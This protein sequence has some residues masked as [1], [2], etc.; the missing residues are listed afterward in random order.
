MMTR[1]RTS[2][3]RSTL[4]RTWTSI[5]SMGSMDRSA[6]NLCYGLHEDEVVRLTPS[7]ETTYDAHLLQS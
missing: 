5:W 3:D 1:E 6:Y 7:A 2:R 4:S